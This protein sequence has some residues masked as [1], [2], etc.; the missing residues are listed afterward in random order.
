M[1][2]TLDQFKKDIKACEPRHIS[3]QTDAC[4]WFFGDVELFHERSHWPWSPF[5][6]MTVEYWSN[7]IYSDLP[8]ANQ[9]AYKFNAKVQKSWYCDDENP[10]WFLIFND[11]D[12]AAKH[13]FNQLKF[14]L[15]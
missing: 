13:A 11:F 14:C 7:T 2:L 9:D 3:R 6:S 12:M 15:I 4:D 8:K 5:K 1:D 10:N